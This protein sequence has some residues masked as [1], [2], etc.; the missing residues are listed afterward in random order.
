[1]ADQREDLHNTRIAFQPTTQQIAA[2]FPKKAP[3]QEDAAA[4]HA[5]ALAEWQQA[6]VMKRQADHAANQAAVALA[7][8]KTKLDAAE[9]AFKA[10]L[11]G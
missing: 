6:A 10:S 8:A 5:K 4:R 9:R 3:V 1:M 7:A 11:E 2:S